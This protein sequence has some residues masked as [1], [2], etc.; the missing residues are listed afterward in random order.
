MIEEF[1]LPLVCERFKNEEHYRN[2]HINI[3]APKPGTR[4]LGVHLPEM[5]SLAKQL[6]KKENWRDILDGF[7]SEQSQMKDNIQPLSH[8]ERLVWGLIISY[9]KCPLEERLERIESFLPAIDN[10]AI[11]DS[12]CCSTKWVE[13][14]D[15]KKVWEYLNDLSLRKEEFSVRVALIMSMSHYLTDEHI[16]KTFAM[17]ERMDLKEGEPYYIKMGVAW[18]LATALAKQREKTYDFIRE[19]ILPTDILKLYKRK[20]RE[21][22]ITKDWN[23]F[24]E[25]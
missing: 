18:L 1:L 23:A 19:N 16:G 20:V 10:W 6:S 25:D 11:C 2:G 12:F 9:V 13:K 4:I 7:E 21:S 22:R 3:V 17:I 8:E 5:K 24:P 15:S 14:S